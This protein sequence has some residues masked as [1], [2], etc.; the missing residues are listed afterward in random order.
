MSKT[1][2]M[3]TCFLVALIGQYTALVLFTGDWRHVLV[4]DKVLVAWH[5]QLPGYKSFTTMSDPPV[6][7]H[8]F[9]MRAYWRV[10]PYYDSEFTPITK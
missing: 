1:R 4:D 9:S 3:W 5:V 10:S 8:Y 7:R 6:T 2:L